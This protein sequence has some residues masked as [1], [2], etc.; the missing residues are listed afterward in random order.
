MFNNV[1]VKNESA[2]AQQKRWFAEK[3]ISLMGTVPN[4]SE[5]AIPKYNNRLSLLMHN[6]VYCCRLNC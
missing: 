6:Y 4:Y 5:V 3:K 2:C 1:K